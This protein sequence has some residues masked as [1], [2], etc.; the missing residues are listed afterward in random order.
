MGI[1]QPRF[2]I[3][4]RG[5]ALLELHFAGFGRFYFRPGEDHA[6]LEAFQ[7]EV[8]VTGLPVVAQDFELWIFLGQFLP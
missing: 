7:K 5:I 1:M 3:F 2:V 6:G 4:N 8:V